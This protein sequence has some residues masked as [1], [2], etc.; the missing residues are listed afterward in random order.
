MCS[1][2]VSYGSVGDVVIVMTPIRLRQIREKL[3][4]SQQEIADILEVSSRSVRN[5]E[6]GHSPLPGS[7][8]IAMEFLDRYG[9]EALTLF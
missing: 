5:W 9:L 1:I 2:G 3:N 7:V 6:K 8:R 4:L